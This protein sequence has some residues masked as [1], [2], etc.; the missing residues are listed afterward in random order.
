MSTPTSE[1]TKTSRTI[2][3]VR[4][5][6]LFNRYTYDLVVPALPHDDPGR[7]VLLYGENGSGKTTA[8]QALKSVHRPKG[9][10]V[11][12][13]AS[14]GRPREVEVRI[15]WAEPGGYITFARW[16]P[17]PSLTHRDPHDSGDSE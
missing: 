3:R 13:I 16:A 5:S 17:G 14:V 1:P 4:V 9:L 7:L 10:A 11:G 2:S 12:T 8:L 15:H 6:K